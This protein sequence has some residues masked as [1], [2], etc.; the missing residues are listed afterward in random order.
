[1]QS[2]SEIILSA[3]NHPGDS[4]VQT[5]TGDNFKGD[6][7]YGRADGVH[8]VQATYTDFDDYTNSASTG[9]KVEAD[10]DDTAVKLSVGYKF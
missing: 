6:R 3:N 5:V 7:Y 9:N 4:T 8:T 2:S 10:F 1:M